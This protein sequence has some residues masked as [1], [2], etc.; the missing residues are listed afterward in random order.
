MIISSIA[1]NA[2]IPPATC[3]AVLPNI[4][5]AVGDWMYAAPSCRNPATA[6]VVNTVSLAL[7]IIFLAPFHGRVGKAHVKKHAAAVIKW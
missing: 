2:T 3:T 4:P 5:R 6:S 7:A 1:I